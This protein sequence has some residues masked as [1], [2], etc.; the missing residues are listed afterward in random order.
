MVHA[1][2]EPL[3]CYHLQHLE[4]YLYNKLPYEK[5]LGIMDLMKGDIGNGK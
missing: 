1:K 4:Y 2:S 5:V 3:F